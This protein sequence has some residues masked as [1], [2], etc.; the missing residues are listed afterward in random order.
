MIK[1]RFKRS[2]IGNMI[3]MGVGG[4]VGATMVGAT[5]NVAAGLPVG[6]AKTITTGVTVPMMATGVAG[7][8]AGYAMK[9]LPRTR[10]RMSRLIRR[11]RH[12]R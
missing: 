11:F 5:A 7:S 9:S 3:K 12:R 1:R 4:I 2:K 10:L 8:M 6:P